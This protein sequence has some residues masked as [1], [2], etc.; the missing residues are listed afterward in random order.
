VKSPEEGLEK[1]RYWYTTARRDL[2]RLPGSIVVIWNH[3]DI[4]HQAVLLAARELGKEVII[5]ENGIAPVSYFWD[6]EG[7][8]NEAALLRNYHSVEVDQE[9]VS[10]IMSRTLYQRPP[11]EDPP[12]FRTAFNPA[13]PYVLFIA[14]VSADTTLTSY[15]EKIINQKEAIESVRNELDFID[16]GIKLVVKPHPYDLAYAQQIEREVPGVSLVHGF[17]VERLVE[18]AKAV[19][20]QNSSVGFWSWMKQKPTV[21]LLP[22]LYQDLC[23]S[24]YGGALGPVLR[25]ALD[26]SM[27]TKTVEEA[28]PFLTALYD[29]SIFGHNIPAFLDAYGR[30]V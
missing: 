12:M 23:L 1:F 17:S 9:K 29:Q 28:G 13:L 18:G 8:V 2:K 6:H 27:R 19:V 21:L 15:T 7:L 30:R 22:A 4:A 5:L 3:N 26:G 10:T 20:T 25:G 24:A 11:I 14:Q 16:Q